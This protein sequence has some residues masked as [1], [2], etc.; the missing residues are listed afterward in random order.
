[1]ADPRDAVD[2]K[3]TSKPAPVDLEVGK[4]R[5]G[6]RPAASIDARRIDH[7]QINVRDLDESAGFYAALLGVELKEQGNNG[8]TRWCILGAP[9]RFYLCLVEVPSAGDFTFEDVHINH[10]GFVVDDIDETVRR[11]HELGLRLGFSDTI[12]DWPRSRSAYVVDPNGIWIEITNRFGG[13]L[14]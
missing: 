10:V 5:A 2:V 13:G 7:V 9:D 3:P 8:G 4:A 11:I 14:G 1:M 12:V 6:L